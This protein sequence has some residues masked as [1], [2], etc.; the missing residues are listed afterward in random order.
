[1]NIR[2]V[3]TT[4]IERDRREIAQ[5]TQKYI[6]GGGQINPCPPGEC[7]HKIKVRWFSESPGLL[8]YIS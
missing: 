4:S 8:K 1:M 7:A 2:P 3:D 6:Q 5:L